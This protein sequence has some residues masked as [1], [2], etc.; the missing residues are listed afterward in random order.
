MSLSGIQSTA[1]DGFGPA[2]NIQPFM[3]YRQRFIWCVYCWG[4][5]SFKTTTRQLGP[6]IK[7][8]FRP[9]SLYKSKLFFQVSCISKLPFN[10]VFCESA[11]TIL[12][13]SMGQFLNELAAGPPQDN[14][15]FNGLV[16]FT[17]LYKENFFLLLRSKCMTSNWALGMRLNNLSDLDIIIFKGF[18]LEPPTVL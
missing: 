5:E 12:E 1:Q 7:W 10:V 11:N 16:C 6:C 3:S 9:Q 15:P 13:P 4:A 17:Y 8:L 14:L 2:F 18:R